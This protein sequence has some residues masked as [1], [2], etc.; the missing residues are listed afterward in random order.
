MKLIGSKKEK[1]IEEG[2]KSTKD[3]L[4][5]QKT[6][7]PWREELLKLD[8]ELRIA[9]MLDF[10]PEQGEDIRTFITDKKEIFII[11]ISRV[12]SSELPICKQIHFQEYKKNLRGKDANLQLIIVLKL[13]EEDLKILENL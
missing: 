1:C 4:F 8:S 3:W 10:I 11:E 6:G 5:N 7:K 13:I 9:Y 12:D 2:L